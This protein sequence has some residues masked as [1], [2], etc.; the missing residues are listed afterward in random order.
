MAITKKKFEEIKNKYGHTSSFAIWGD[1]VDDMSIFDDEKEPWGHINDYCAIVALNPA[2]E[3][4][5][6]ENFHSSNKK[7]GDN[8]LM[9]SI[10][11]TKLEGSFMTDLSKYVTPDSRQVK[12]SI[13]DINDLIA[14]LK[15][16]GKID[17][18]A[19]FSSKAKYIDKILESKGFKVIRFLHYSFQN[20]NGI[21]R[22]CIKNSLDISDKNGNEKCVIAL[23][24]Q[25]MKAGF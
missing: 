25:I 1:E 19:I 8:R 10:R 14:T 16:V 13:D 11:G 9:L 20:G 22:Y 6:L 23:K 7:H 12:I 21:L 17:T 18:I 5:F 4:G 24:H 3:I 2:N 15:E